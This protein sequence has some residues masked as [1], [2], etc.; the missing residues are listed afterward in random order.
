M[1]LPQNRRSPALGFNSASNQLT[2]RHHHQAAAHWTWKGFSPFLQP[3][4]HFSR[5]AAKVKHVHLIATNHITPN[6]W[7]ACQWHQSQASFQGEHLPTGRSMREFAF[8]PHL[9]LSPAQCCQWRWETL[10]Q[11]TRIHTGWIYPIAEPRLQHDQDRHTVPAT[12][13]IDFCSWAILLRM[14]QYFKI[15]DQKKW[16]TPQFSS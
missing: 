13:E 14:K 9:H 8:F 16:G 4:E 10:P 6:F 2:K 1:F 5:H 15:R 3:P 7:N 11:D 12:D